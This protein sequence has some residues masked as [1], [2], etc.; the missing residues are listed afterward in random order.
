MRSIDGLGVDLG[1]KNEK[2][3]ALFTSVLHNLVELFTGLLVCSFLNGCLV[4]VAEL[5][6]ER[7]LRRISLSIFLL[8]S[9]GELGHGFEVELVFEIVHPLSDL[10]SLNPQAK[11]R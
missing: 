4:F 5:A 8:E 7:V 2:V 1:L 6:L 11:Q 3:L 9:L 10:V